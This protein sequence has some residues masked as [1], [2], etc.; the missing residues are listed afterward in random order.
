[1]KLLKS[2]KDGFTMIE[3]LV[4]I[5]LIALL[6]IGMTSI[7]KEVVSRARAGIIATETKAIVDGFDLYAQKLN[8]TEW[9]QDDTMTD[10]GNNPY[11]DD[12][13]AQNPLFAKYVHP[14]PHISGLEG[15][16][17]R[18][19]NEGN[20]FTCGVGN[21]RQGVNLTIRNIK[22]VSIVKKVNEIIDGD[23]DLTCGRL[24][25]SSA[26][27]GTLVYGISRIQEIR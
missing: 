27:N 18:Y 20:T 22:D 4:V 3:L 25:W 11:I 10:T 24:R 1:M 7:Y 17:W 12:I 13:I 14:V 16:E 6:T 2:A 8:L 23:N 19:D 21:T 5:A 9:P 26:Y 15:L